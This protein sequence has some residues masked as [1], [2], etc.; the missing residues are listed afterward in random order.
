MLLLP[1]TQVG[2][3]LKQCWTRKIRSLYQMR[4]TTQVFPCCE[5]QGTPRKDHYEVHCWRL[6][7]VL[8]ASYP[9]DVCNSSSTEYILNNLMMKTDWIFSELCLNIKWL[10]I[11]PDSSLSRKLRPYYTDSILLWVIGCLIQMQGRS[12]TGTKNI[13][14]IF[15]FPYCTY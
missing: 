10:T 6:T 1:P 11:T 8:F 9:W 12:E 14:T 4:W 3:V 7:E 13:W 2:N 15:S 5:P